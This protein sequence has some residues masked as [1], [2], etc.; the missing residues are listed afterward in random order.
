MEL[1]RYEKLSLMRVNKW[2]KEKYG[3]G[4]KRILDAVSKPIDYLIKKI[5]PE[6]FRHFESAIEATA[7][8]MLYASTY[9]VNEKELIKRAHK[10]GIMIEDLSELK[11]VNFKLIDDCNKKHIK[12]H[13]RASAVQGAVAGIGGALIA[14]ADLTAILL[15]VFHLLQE[16]ASC[17]AYDPNDIVE[18]NIILR[19][20]EAGLGSSENKFKALQEIEMLKK[21]ESHGE[22]TQISKK[23]VSVLGSKAIKESIENLSVSLLSRLIPRAL[24]IPIITM[25]ISAHS[26]HE[27]MEN[28]G[29]AA[30]MVYRKRFIARKMEL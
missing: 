24:P 22:E 12:I 26:N 28:S 7:N 4:R 20:M 15:Q 14:T 5:G 30:L 6:K 16:I 8:K 18:K 21:I 11:T 23:S 27:I 9:S 10:N 17:Y 29:E 13:E 25:A 1:T 3:G 2:E 19:I